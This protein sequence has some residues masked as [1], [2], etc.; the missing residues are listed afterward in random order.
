MIKIRKR[1]GNLLARPDQWKKIIK[2]ATLM[3]AAA[4]FSPVSMLTSLS[5]RRSLRHNSLRRESCCVAA[6]H[7]TPQICLY[8]WWHLGP[9]YCNAKGSHHMKEAARGRPP[10]RSNAHV[11]IK[12]C[13]ASGEE[14]N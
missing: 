4:P 1:F 2:A 12:I 14:N 3:K 7:V 11:R 6:R 8:F 13:E 9:S 10:R 5:Y